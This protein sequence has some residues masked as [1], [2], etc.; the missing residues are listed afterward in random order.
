[1]RSS[2]ESTFGN[3]YTC[4]SC[5]VVRVVFGIEAVVGAGESHLFFGFPEREVDVNWVSIKLEGGVVDELGE[6]RLLYAGCSW[7]FSFS[8]CRDQNEGVLRGPRV[9][10]VFLVE[11]CLDKAERILEGIQVPTSD[12]GMWT[13]GD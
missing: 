4:S 5:E 1:V 9:E 13:A 7:A 8:V 10:E 2:E 11:C 6:S 12:S 3:A